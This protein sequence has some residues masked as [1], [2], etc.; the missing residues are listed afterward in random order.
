MASPDSVKKPQHLED[1]LNRVSK[2]LAAGA[3]ALA[4]VL[5]GAVSASATTSYPGGGTWI[6]GVYSGGTW[7]TGGTVRSDYYHASAIHRSTACNGAGSCT[8]L[9][10]YSAGAWSYARIPATASGNTAFWNKL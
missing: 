8:S 5:G 9:P 10:W 2:V 3:V 6:Y 7:G 4:L 1:A